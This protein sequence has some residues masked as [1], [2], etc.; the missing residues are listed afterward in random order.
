MLKCF[1]LNQ[2][3]SEEECKNTIEQS[4]QNKPIIPKKFKRIVG[5]KYICKECPNHKN[6]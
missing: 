4:Y 1:V 5:W 2:E 3:I 6:K